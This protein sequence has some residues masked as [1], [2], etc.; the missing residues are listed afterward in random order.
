MSTYTL[1]QAIKPSRASIVSTLSGGKAR[2]EDDELPDYISPEPKNAAER[3]D[4][5]RMS[6]RMEGFH[7]Y[8]RHSF[9]QLFELSDGSFNERGMTV[10]DFMRLAEDFLMHLEFHHSIEEQ[11]IFPILA[12]RM[13]QFRVDHQE[14]HDTIHK[15]MHEL[16]WLAKRF[17]LDPT[18]YSPDE[19]RQN[20]VSWGPLL[21]YHLDAEV[22]SLKPD[23]LRRYWTLQEAKHLPM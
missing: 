11:H 6:S 23:I 9:R 22:A 8:F 14:E 16:R 5:E 3:R 21:F 1:E 7:A 4:W 10:R 19:F 2:E 15:G 13:P 12:K 17:K 18:A 20:L